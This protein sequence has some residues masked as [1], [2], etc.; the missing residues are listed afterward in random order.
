VVGA[1][2]AGVVVGTGV[3]AAVGTGVDA[4]VG[5]LTEVDE[6]MDSGGEVVGVEKGDGR[7]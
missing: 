7:T 4:G 3:C 6:V 2:G 1:T 5:G